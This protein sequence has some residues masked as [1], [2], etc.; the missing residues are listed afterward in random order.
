MC[1][2]IFGGER[3]MCKGCSGECLLWSIGAELVGLLGIFILL[4]I[5]FGFLIHLFSAG[6]CT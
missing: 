5:E 2:W 1:G 3:Y 4:E 6:V